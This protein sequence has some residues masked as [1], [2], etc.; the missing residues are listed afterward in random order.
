MRSVILYQFPHSGL[1]GKHVCLQLQDSGFDFSVSRLI[2][3]L[4]IIEYDQ[5]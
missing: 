4:G 5:Y 3:K 1:L 2:N